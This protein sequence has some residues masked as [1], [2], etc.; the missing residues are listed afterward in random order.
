M[1]KLIKNCMVDKN[2]NKLTSFSAAHIKEINLLCKH[3][4]RISP[5]TVLEVEYLKI[6]PQP[7]DPSTPR[8]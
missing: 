6:A 2:T 4:A 7:L 3:A 8:C 1:H 5:T